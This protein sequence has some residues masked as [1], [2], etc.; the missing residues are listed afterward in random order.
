MLF[1]GEGAYLEVKLIDNHI[2]YVLIELFISLNF[3]AMFF[4][5]YIFFGFDL[6]FVHYIIFRLLISVCIQLHPIQIISHYYSISLG[7]LIDVIILN[8]SIFSKYYRRQHSRV[9]VASVSMH[10][11]FSTSN[12]M[13]SIYFDCCTP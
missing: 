1:L 6:F 7:H 3:Y 4:E 2:S 8:Y 5:W 11:Y 9:N 13:F 10:I 12:V